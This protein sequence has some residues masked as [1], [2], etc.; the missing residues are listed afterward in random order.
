MIPMDI[1]VGILVKLFYSMNSKMTYAR[2][3]GKDRHSSRPS[4]ILCMIVY[5]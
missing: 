4:L 2:I 1:D 5:L 3:T